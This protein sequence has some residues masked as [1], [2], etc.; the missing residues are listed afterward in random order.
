[1]LAVKSS[2]APKEGFLQLENKLLRKGTEVLWMA[3]EPA[4]LPL[5]PG[6]KDQGEIRLY[7]VVP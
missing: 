3:R 5:I 7:Q 6:I 4:H 1:M 2:D